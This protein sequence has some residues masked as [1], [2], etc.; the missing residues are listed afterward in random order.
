MKKC[1]QIFAK[2]E[3]EYNVCNGFTLIKFRYYTIIIGIIFY[4]TRRIFRQCKYNFTR[5]SCRNFWKDNDFWRNGCAIKLFIEAY[6][7]T[8]AKDFVVF[9]VLNLRLIYGRIAFTHPFDFMPH[10]FK[11]NMRSV[12]CLW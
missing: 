11:A 9:F 6:S 12:R 4:R 1:T 5:V 8:N 2:F 7:E 10:D 3:N